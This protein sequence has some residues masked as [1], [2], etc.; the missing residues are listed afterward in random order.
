MRGQPKPVRSRLAPVK[1]AITLCSHMPGSFPA[2]HAMVAAT[3]YSGMVWTMATIA[4]AS[5]LLIEASEASAAQAINNEAPMTA[6]EVK[7]ATKYT[8]LGAKWTTAM[9]S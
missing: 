5:P 4:S 7:Q 6:P 3:K 2:F 8:K 1:L 9:A